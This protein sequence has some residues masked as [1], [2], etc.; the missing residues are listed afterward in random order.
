MG[1]KDIA[2]SS[3]N[4]AREVS[5]SNEN[6]QHIQKLMNEA[7]DPIKQTLSQSKKINV[8]VHELNDLL[9]EFQLLQ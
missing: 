4:A 1:V 7:S 5:H 9:Q 8:T 6:I 3:H 2:S